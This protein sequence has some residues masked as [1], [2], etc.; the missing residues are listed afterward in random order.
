M[1]HVL[2]SVIK[3]T[4][5]RSNNSMEKNGYVKPKTYRQFNLTLKIKYTKLLLIKYVLLTKVRA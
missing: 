5:T 4:Q 2:S 1:K 3:T